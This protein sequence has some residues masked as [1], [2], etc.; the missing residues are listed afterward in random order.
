M[1]KGK[2]RGRPSKHP[3]AEMYVG[4]SVEVFDNVDYMRVY[5]HSYGRSS[6]KKFTTKTDYGRMVVKRIE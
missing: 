6:G 1:T 2:K 3:Y 5:A 4:D